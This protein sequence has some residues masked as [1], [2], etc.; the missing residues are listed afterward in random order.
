MRMWDASSDIYFTSLS[1]QVIF[2]LAAV[3][4]A[5]A[6]VLVEDGSYVDLEPPI[7]YAFSYAAGRFP[8]HVDRTHSETRDENGI[9]RGNCNEPGRKQRTAK[10]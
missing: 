8:G 10:M 5:S 6:D 2:L 9:I 3:V 1:A 7:P 4:A